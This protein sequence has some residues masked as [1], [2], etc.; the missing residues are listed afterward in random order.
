MNLIQNLEQKIKFSLLLCLLCFI[1]MV[2]VIGLSFSY[3]SN[4]IAKDRKQIYVLS[5]SIPLTAT[6]TSIENNR[7]AEY[8]ASV[9]LFHNYFFCLPPDNNFIELQLNKAMYLVDASG[10]AQYNTL[11]EHG[12]FSTLISS[13][14][15]VTLTKDS[16]V[17]NTENKTWIYYGK[18]KIE[19]PSNITIRSLITE[20]SLQD[21]PR[22]INNPHGVLITNWKTIENKDL[23]NETKKIF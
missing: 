2:V 6:Q 1:T 17:M 14:S 12:Y 5:G 18:E 9:D 4:M 23:T 15:V 20:G 21:I 13:S 22:T 11:K 7:E 3:A 10:I 16:I 8:I 19:R